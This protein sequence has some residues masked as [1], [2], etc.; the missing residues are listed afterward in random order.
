MTKSAPS[1]SYVDDCAATFRRR[2]TAERSRAANRAAELSRR[3]EEAAAT[4]VGKCGATRVWLFGSLAWGE[5]HAGSDV[6]LLVEGLPSEAWSV[7]CALAEAVVQA[8][9]D[10]IRVEEASPEL[11]ARVRDRGVLLH[12]AD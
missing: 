12:G 3:A 10:L 7:A 8:P 6:D 2:L 11:V 5:A 1:R 4:L 9:V